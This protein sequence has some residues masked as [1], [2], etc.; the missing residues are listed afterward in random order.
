MS[1]YW[2]VDYLMIFLF[3][4]E[5]ILLG[6]LP[7]DRSLWASELSKKRSQYK[8]FKDDLLRNPVS[9]LNQF[10]KI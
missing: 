7:S 9:P 5:Q 2:L 10:Y 3:V 1:D 4:P 6:Y 8:A